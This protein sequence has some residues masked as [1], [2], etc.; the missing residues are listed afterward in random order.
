MN[1][2]SRNIQKR[3][4]IEIY[5][6]L[7]ALGITLCFSSF[8]RS[9]NIDKRALV[10]AIGVDRGE[11]KLYKVTMQIFKPTSAGSDTPVDVSQ[12]NVQNVQ[13]QGDTIQEAVENASLKLGREIF[14]GHLQFICFSK[15]IDFSEPSQLFQFALKDNNVYLGVELCLAENSA[16]DIINVQISGNSTS[17]EAV[18]S[19]IEKNIDSSA[20]VECRMLDFLSSIDAPQNIAVPVLGID[21]TGEKSSE[22]ENSSKGTEDSQENSGESEII[23]KETALIKDGKVLEQ[24][25]DASQSQGAAWLSKKAKK[26]SM[27]VQLENGNTQWVNVTRDDIKIKLEDTQKGMRLDVEIDAV[28]HSGQGAKTQDFSLSI[29]RKVKENLE[30]F[31]LDAWE[32]TIK[33]NKVDIIGIWKL[34]RRDYPK[35]YLENK[36]HLDKMYDNC[37]LNLNVKVKV[38]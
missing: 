22:S 10:H 31:C 29:Q 26:T 33:E 30:K 34:F 12:P 28:A 3:R 1:R 15:D 2:L 35:S 37:S 23:V 32:K 13:T 5:V 27:A 8:G 11:D 18:K 16:Q 21:S 6:L 25:L 19:I 20:T 7:L 14:L 9:V 36:D 24:A 38:E 17:S 4:N